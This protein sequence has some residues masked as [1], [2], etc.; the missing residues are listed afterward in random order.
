MNNIIVM[1]YFCLLT[2]YRVTSNSLASSLVMI[3]SSFG[4]V[5]EDRVSVRFQAGLLLCATASKTCSKQPE[6]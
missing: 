1:F 3:H 2:V 6:S 4:I 5:F